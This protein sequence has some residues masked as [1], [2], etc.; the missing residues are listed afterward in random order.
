MIKS[1]TTPTVTITEVTDPAELAASKASWECLEKNTAW[2]EANASEV[3]SHRGKYICI[4][5]Q[6]LFVGDDVLEVVARA[7]AAHPDDTGYFTQY[8]PLKKVAR[9]YEIQRLVASL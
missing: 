3:Y 2:L 7:R 5:G 4:A 9:I 8:V 1:L 6:H